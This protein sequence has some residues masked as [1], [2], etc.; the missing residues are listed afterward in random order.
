MQ[1]ADREQGFGGTFATTRLDRAIA[2]FRSHVHNRRGL[3][4]VVNW[5]RSWSLYPYPFA[6]ACC[7]ME[8]M[9]VVGPRHDISRFGSEAVRFTPR[10]ADVLFV[11]GTITH[12]QAPILERTYLAMAE[13]KWVIAIGVCASSGGFYNNY[14]VV[15]GIDNFLPVDVYVP[16]CPP[17]PEAILDALLLLQQKVREEQPT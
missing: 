10:Q 6:T 14:S 11:L 2:A 8:F 12:K 13:P 7:G 3:N 17:R 9:S 16:G 15:Q 1:P 5:G 4:K